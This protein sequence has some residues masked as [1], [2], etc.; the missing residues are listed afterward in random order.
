MLSERVSDYALVDVP[1]LEGE[2]GRAVLHAAIVS[3]LEA[4]GDDDR[5]VNF[6][7][8]A[9]SA[10]GDVELTQAWTHDTAG[11]VIPYGL[12]VGGYEYT[13]VID[14]DL[15]HPVSGEPQGHG[16]VSTVVLAFNALTTLDPRG[17]ATVLGFEVQAT[18]PLED[19]PVTGEIAFA[20]D[21]R[22][23]GQPVRNLASVR[24]DLTP[25]CRCQS[26]AVR[27]VPASLTPFIRGDANAD[28]DFDVSDAIFMLEWLFLGGETPS[29]FDSADLNASRTI[30]L[31]DSI[32]ALQFLFAG[33]PPPA[34]PYPDCGLPELPSAEGV[35]PVSGC[36]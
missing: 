10:R 8:L 3:S 35:C 36:A 25:F 14:P 7:S 11:A 28:G 30:D 15:I 6:W 16:V 31:S 29:C 32:S 27:F 26:A 20:D 21:L 12:R 5:G 34:A 18:I 24:F 33:G 17:T 19:S 23:S 2:L 9:L 13:E 4:V 1:T 22:G